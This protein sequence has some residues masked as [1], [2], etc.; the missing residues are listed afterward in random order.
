[1]RPTFQLGAVSHPTRRY[2]LWVGAAPRHNSF[3]VGASQLSGRLHAARRTENIRP[4]TRGPSNSHSHAHT[5]NDADCDHSR[6]HAADANG[7]R[8]QLYSDAY[9]DCDRNAYY[10]PDAAFGH[11]DHYRHIA[12]P[13][14]NAN[15][16]SE[17]AAF[18]YASVTVCNANRLAAAAICDVFADRDAFADCNAAAAY[19]DSADKHFAADCAYVAFAATI[20]SEELA[21]PCEG[22][23]NLRKDEH[24][25][26]HVTCADACLILLML[27]C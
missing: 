14:P 20:S 2:T 23:S 24:S 15:R 25:G 3:C 12:A 16:Q 21:H 18:G 1:M 26:T 5:Y 4:A 9:T 22:F 6:H 7:D 27:Y 8:A 11:A 13:Y 19:G 17:R 10:R